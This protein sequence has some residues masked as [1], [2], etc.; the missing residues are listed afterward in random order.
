MLSRRLSVIFCRAV[1]LANAGSPNSLLILW[2]TLWLPFE[3][4]YF[5]TGPTSNYI[6]NAIDFF[7]IGFIGI[8]ITK[9]IFEST[10]TDS[11]D[12]LFST[13]IEDYLYGSLQ[14]IVGNT[15][16]MAVNSNCSHIHINIELR[17]SPKR[18]T[19]FLSGTDSL[20]VCFSSVPNAKISGLRFRW[21]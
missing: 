8:K 2:G 9:D 12:S 7:D 13:I 19:R 18:Y 11:I 3:C 21:T 5:S 14:Q 20:L 16:T 6:E 4:L 15:N 17:I 1:L 10:S